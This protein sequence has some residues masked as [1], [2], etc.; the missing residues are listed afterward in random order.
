MHLSMSAIH[1]NASAILNPQADQLLYALLVW[2]DL[3]IRAV[4]LLFGL[5]VAASMVLV[6]LRHRYNQR[7]FDS[8]ALIGQ[9]K[10]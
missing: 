2:F 10:H 9:L 3:P 5:F 1:R 4:M 7:Q 6:M 8:I